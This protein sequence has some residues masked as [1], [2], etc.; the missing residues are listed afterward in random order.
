MI[1]WHRRLE[2][3]PSRQKPMSRVALHFT[4]KGLSVNL[5]ARSPG[6]Y[7]AVNCATA[8]M[9]TAFRF[10]TVSKNNYIN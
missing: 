2:E 4:D 8:S 5:A 3:G 1:R 9:I 10:M 7:S 6:Y